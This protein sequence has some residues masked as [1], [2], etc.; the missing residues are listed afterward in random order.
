MK[1]L[2]EL[3]RKIDKTEN[4]EIVGGNAVYAFEAAILKAIAG[5][6]KK[7]LWQFLNG[8]PKILPKPL[9]N[10]IGGGKHTNQEKKTDFQEFL[11]LPNTKSF[12]DAQ[13]INL[14]AYKEAKKNILEKDSEWEGSLTDESAIATTL[15]DELVLNLL[16]EIS[17]KIKADFNVELGLGIDMASSSLFAG[18]NYLYKNP[19]KQKRLSQEQQIEYVS[20]LIE[21]HNLVYVEDPLEEEDFDGFARLLRIVSIKNPKCLIVGDDLICTKY[22]RLKKAIQKKSI[23]AVIIKPN[24]NGSLIETKKVVAKTKMAAS[25]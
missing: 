5:N 18:A 16:L 19:L 25:A 7:P 1:I 9:G 22:E 21:K 11:L 3:I 14:Q 8:N 17:K 23:N 12:H 20:K 15:D 13:F 2:E 6:H 24:Q 10:C 4:F